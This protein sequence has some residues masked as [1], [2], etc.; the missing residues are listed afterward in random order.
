MGNFTA[1]L[2]LE[3]Y[4]LTSRIHPN[5]LIVYV[6]ASLEEISGDSDPSAQLGVVNNHGN[7]AVGVSW[8]SP[9]NHLGIRV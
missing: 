9:N 1:L 2:A 7:A 6:L 4:T 3:L 8:R 5:A